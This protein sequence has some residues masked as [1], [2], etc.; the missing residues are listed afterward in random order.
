M[1]FRITDIHH[2]TMN[3]FESDNINEMITVATVMSRSSESK[4]AGTFFITTDE[5]PDDNNVVLH[6]FHNGIQYNP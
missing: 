6:I 5:I 2:K 4:N 3:N 1:S